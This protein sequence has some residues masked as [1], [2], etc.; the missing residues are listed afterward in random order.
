MATNKS[1]YFQALEYLVENDL[2]SSPKKELLIS[3]KYDGLNFMP[4]RSISGF[5]VKFLKD[6]GKPDDLHFINGFSRIFEIEPIDVLEE[7]LQLKI[8]VL[9]SL[10]SNKSNFDALIQTLLPHEQ[11]KVLHLVE[12]NQNNINLLMNI[13]WHRFEFQLNSDQGQFILSNHERVI[14][15]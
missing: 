1:I 11:E 15:N 12:A 13:E 4:P 6:S 8:N 10:N 3:Y 7:T 5:K 14:I 9:L 2:K